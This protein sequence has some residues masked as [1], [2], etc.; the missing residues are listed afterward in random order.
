MA[1]VPGALAPGPDV[2]NKL[3]LLLLPPPPPPSLL[4]LLMMMMMMMIIIII[5]IGTYQRAGST[6]HVPVTKPASEHN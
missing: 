1:A 6:A 3:L 4:L 5:I 2:T